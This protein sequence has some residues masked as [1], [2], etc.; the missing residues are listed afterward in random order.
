M[1]LK[2]APLTK[3]TGMALPTNTLLYFQNETMGKLEIKSKVRCY[4]SEVSRDIWKIENW[5]FYQVA[6]KEEYILWMLEQ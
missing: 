3:K 4:R 5:G 2:S 6:S 1:N